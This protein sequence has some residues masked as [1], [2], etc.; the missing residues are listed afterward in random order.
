MENTENNSAEASKSGNGFGTIIGITIIVI[1][2]LAGAW[3]FLG[4]RVAKLEEQK[5][6]STV[7]DESKLSTSTEVV[8]LQADLGKIDMEVLDQQ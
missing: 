8:D 7:I 3:Y 1:V 5:Q 2:L 4:Q 6:I